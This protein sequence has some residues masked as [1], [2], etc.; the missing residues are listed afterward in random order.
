[1]SLIK[2]APE[3]LERTIGQKLPAVVSQTVSVQCRNRAAPSPSA[4]GSRPNTTALD[5]AFCC[6]DQNL[7]LDLPGNPAVQRSI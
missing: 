1:M 3:M 5:F 7:I 4:H 2:M 6:F